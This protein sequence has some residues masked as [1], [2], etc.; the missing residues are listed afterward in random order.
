MSEL[1][2]PIGAILGKFY[3]ELLG[4]PYEIWDINAKKLSEYLRKLI[5]NKNIDYNNYNPDGNVEKILSSHLDKYLKSIQNI[6]YSIE[7]FV[8]TPQKFLKK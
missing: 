3:D 7:L 5:K 2:F 8:N 4:S 6:T 1:I